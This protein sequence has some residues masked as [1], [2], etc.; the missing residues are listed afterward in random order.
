MASS[1][2]FRRLLAWP[3]LAVN[4]LIAP[5][6]DTNV[7]R[8]VQKSLCGDFVPPFCSMWKGLLLSTSNFNGGQ[9]KGTRH[10]HKVRLRIEKV[11]PCR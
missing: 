2:G 10:T 5:S 4:Y 9:K 3:T 6:L 7:F 8:C 11:C 1:C